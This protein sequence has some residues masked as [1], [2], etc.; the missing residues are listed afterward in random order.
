[1]AALRRPQQ[2][3]SPSSAS[4][5]QQYHHHPAPLLPP[6]S[7]KSVRKRRRSPSPQSDDGSGAEDSWPRSKR[8]TQLNPASPLSSSPPYKA[9]TIKQEQRRSYG[10]HKKGKRQVL[11][12]DSTTEDITTS[13]VPSVKRTRLPSVA[14]C[15]FAKAG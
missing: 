15:K 14:A 4:K 6:P 3:S 8:V 9:S 13:S 10:S 11:M 1:M 12:H 5:T 2:S 7:A